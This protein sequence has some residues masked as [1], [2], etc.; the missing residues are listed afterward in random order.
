MNKRTMTLVA[1]LAALSAG[2]SLVAISQANEAK[3]TYRTLALCLAAYDR[4]RAL[5]IE[6]NARLVNATAL[7]GDEHKAI[8][9]QG[10]H[11]KKAGIIRHVCDEMKRHE[12]PMADQVKELTGLLDGLGPTGGSVKAPVAGVVRQNNLSNA[13]EKMEQLGGTLDQAL[14]DFR[15]SDFGSNSAGVRSSAPTGKPDP[16]LGVQVASALRADIAKWN[17]E[18]KAR[19][20]EGKRLAAIEIERRRIEMAA[21]VEQQRESYAEQQASKS[22]GFWDTLGVIASVSVGVAVGL[23]EGGNSKTAQVIQNMANVHPLADA[24]RSSVVGSNENLDRQCPGLMNRL[25]SIQQEQVNGICQGLD[26]ELSYSRRF[27]AM[28][29][30]CSH[31]YA[32]E[33]LKGVKATIASTLDAKRTAGC[34]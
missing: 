6:A 15:A 19:E 24:G 8:M 25:N 20:D 10:K 12:R 13:G 4:E 33:S 14:A 2:V 29:L 18:E 28:L 31:P 3:P 21:R 5:E 27:E 22:S 26:A 17:L 9:E 34:T 23:R 32:L 30:S 7:S 11:A 1:T 16:A